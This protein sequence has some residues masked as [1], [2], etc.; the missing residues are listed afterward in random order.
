MLAVVVVSAS[1]CTAC[2]NDDKGVPEAQ[3]STTTVALTTT[4]APNP[5]LIKDFSFSGL[6]VKAGT[7]VLVQNQGTQPHT[8]TADNRQFD[9]GQVPPG[10]NVEFTVPAQP[11][12]YKVKCLVHPDR[13][14]GEL[15]VT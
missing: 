2:G 6:E 8:L 10:R 4:A 3:S 12:T 5:I 13:M 9:T 14:Q 7:K 11:G 1:V 15:K